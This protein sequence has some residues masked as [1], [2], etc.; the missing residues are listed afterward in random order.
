[1]KK[2][3]FTLGRM[4]DFKN[5][6]LDK[7]KDTLGRI[8]REKNEIDEKILRYERQLAEASDKM[9][10]KQSQGVPARQL[11]LYSIQAEHTRQ[12][13]KQ[14]R[15]EQLALEKEVER[16]TEVVRK[17]SQDVSS[18]EKLKE[19][20]WEQYCYEANKAYQEEILEFVSGRLVRT[21]R[22]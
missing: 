5:Q 10:A 2:F 7:E 3:H 21:E 9:I 19:R 14:L 17:A 22:R 18:L 20:Q 16:Q 15:K 4:L 1:M 8:R 11:I 12:Y 13:L 6:I